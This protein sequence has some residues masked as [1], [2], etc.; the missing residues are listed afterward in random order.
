MGPHHRPW[1]R[2][3]PGGLT[4]PIS[5]E[6]VRFSTA[7]TK[8]PRDTD[9]KGED[10][11]MVQSEDWLGGVLS[12]AHL[13]AFELLVPSQGGRYGD[14]RVA[15]VGLFWS[16][17]HLPSVFW[18]SC[19]QLASLR[20]IHGFRGAINSSE[21]TISRF[22]LT[23]CL[24]LVQFTSL[25]YFLYILKKCVLKLLAAWQT[26]T[27]KLGNFYPKCSHM[28]FTP[29][30]SFTKNGSLPLFLNQRP[31]H[32]KLS[33]SPR[34]SQELCDKASFLLKLLLVTASLSQRV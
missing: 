20:C 29:N 10:I 32:H 8:W 15:L 33:S 6:A 2:C 13:V 4:F 24:H 31:S 23:V 11:Q 16:F 34:D 14:S 17:F 18:A 9:A 25:F 28:A 27:L 3:Q 12:P 26:L 7:V 30:S 19:P 5:R 22:S 1:P 21:T